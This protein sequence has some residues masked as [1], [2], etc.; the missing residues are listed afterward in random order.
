MPELPTG[1]DT[2]RPHPARTYDYFLG[3]KDNFAADREVAD[4]VL[5][6]WPAIRLGVRENRKFLKRAVRYLAGE[7]GIRQF[8]DIGTGLPTAENV[9]EV[10]QAVA[11]SARVVYV[12]N[13]PLVLAHARALLTS[14]PEG[15]TA[16]IHAD[17]RDPAAILNDP[18]TRDV[19]DFTQPVALMLVAILH[20]IPDEEKPAEIVATLLDAL[21]PGSYLVASHITAQHSEGAAAAEDR[22]NE[23]NLSAR[24]RDAGVFARL[25]FAGLDLVP[26]GVVLTSEWRND[27]PGPR[28][29]P[30]EISA[31]CGVARRP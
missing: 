1:I 31:Y 3:G 21:P 13:D 15:R 8:L 18:V 29:T 30:A 12:D 7:A 28:P 10:A 9:H 17:L 22:F 25:A 23:A 2:S 4:K 26:P 20:M 5:A 19:L 11:R 16:Y 27:E 6:G 24:W 14:S